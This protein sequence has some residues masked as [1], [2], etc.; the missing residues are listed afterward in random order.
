MADA[1]KANR[2]YDATRRQQAA[3]ATRQSILIAAQERFLADGYAATTLSGLASRVGVSVETIYK[4]FGSKAGLLR[5]V[6]DRA[7]LGDEPVAPYQ[8]ADEAGATEKDP[9]RLISRWAGLAA[10]VTPRVAPVLLL[11][12]DAA[13]TAPELRALWNELEDRRLRRMAENAQHLVDGG[14]L[15]A[16]RTPDQA[17]DVLW[18]YTSPELYERLVLRQGWPLVEYEAFLRDGMIGALLGADR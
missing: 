6:H 17:R 3:R 11:V 8:R 5:A 13:A 12:R 9:Y 10:E 7:L 2:R 15:R 14:H 18:A 1:V 4:Q 16:E